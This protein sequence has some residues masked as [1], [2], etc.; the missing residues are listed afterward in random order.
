V[1][2]TDIPVAVEARF[3][4][5]GTITPLALEWQGRGLPISDVGR[6]WATADGQ[7]RCWLVMI[8]ARGTFELCLNTTTLRWRITRAWEPPTLAKVHNLRK[9]A[10]VPNNSPPVS[11][12]H[13]DR[14]IRL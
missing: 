9:G 3:D 4:A 13:T 8:A 12:L 1:N 7:L 5:D 10:P 6:S 14:Y 11:V 2:F